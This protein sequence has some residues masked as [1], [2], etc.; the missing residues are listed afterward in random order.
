MANKMTLCLVWP[1]IANLREKI[2]WMN[3]NVKNKAE[4][5]FSCAL[6]CQ[7]SHFERYCF[8]VG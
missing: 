7:V 4:T 5:S 8:V 2:E 3:Q 1:N 6:Q